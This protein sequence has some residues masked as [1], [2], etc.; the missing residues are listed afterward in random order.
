VAIALLLV[1]FVP[2]VRDRENAYF[3]V[4]PTESH[5]VHAGFPGKVSAVYVKEG[6]IVHRGQVMARLQSLTEAGARQEAE[7][8]LASSQAQVFAAELQHTG[9]GEA[10]AAQ[11]AAR[12]SSTNASQESALLAVT[13]P[14]GGVVATSDPESLLNRDVATGETLL[15]IVD[16]TQMVARL[17]VP[18]SAM[19]RVQVG[20]AVSLQP[21]SQFSEIRGRLGTMEGSAMPL[22][23]G[24]LAGQA[25]KGIALPA[26]YTTRMPLAKMADGIRPGMSG[27]A[28]IFGRRR[29][30]ANR[31]LTTLGNML[32][33]HF[34]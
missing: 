20:D 4:E 26:F 30:L 2:I 28:I 15:T 19:D 18:V 25:Y 29:S 22:P 16:P 21:T 1:F 31:M 23:S 11:H 8:Q 9:L 5:Q 24:L 17:F 13:A 3:V 32:R 12:Q 14:A 6:D 10:L 33:T 7:A 27:R 34:W